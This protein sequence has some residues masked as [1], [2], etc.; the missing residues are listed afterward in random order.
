MEIIKSLSNLDYPLYIIRFWLLSDKM[1]GLSHNDISME[2][3]QTSIVKAVKTIRSSENVQMSSRYKKFVTKELH[4]ITN[5]DV[6]NILK[7]LSEMGR[8]ENKPSKDRSSFP[9]WQ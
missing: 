8:I 1:D 4:L 9:W 5:T 3:L 6:N 7:M 2:T